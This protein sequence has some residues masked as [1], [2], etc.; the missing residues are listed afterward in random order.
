MWESLCSHILNIENTSPSHGL[1]QD[2]HLNLSG[3][4]SH[5][6]SWHISS[7]VFL[8][9]K[10]DEGRDILSMTDGS[11]FPGFIWS[12]PLYCRFWLYLVTSSHGCSSLF[13]NIQFSPRFCFLVISGISALDKTGNPRQGWGV[14]SAPIS[15][16][17][18]QQISPCS[19]LFL[20]SHWWMDP[21]GV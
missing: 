7:T 4:Q 11:G 6:Q 1:Q 3:S 10:S 14:V 12:N 17:A 16:Q 8:E 5:V 9:L 2:N 13:S 20:C 19:P 18:A 15:H 21:D